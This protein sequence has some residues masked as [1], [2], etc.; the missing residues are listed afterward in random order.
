M[1]VCDDCLLVEVNFGNMPILSIQIHGARLRNNVWTNGDIILPL[2][3]LEIQ[4]LFKDRNR[5]SV[6]QNNSFTFELISQ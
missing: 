1:N 5:K 3:Q 4:F 2:N 6:H